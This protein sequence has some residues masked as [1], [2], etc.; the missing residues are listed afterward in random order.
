MKNIHSLLLLERVVGGRCNDSVCC[1]EVYIKSPWTALVIT[2]TLLSE[3][4]PIIE[5][6]TGAMTL[7]L[8]GILNY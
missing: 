8:R 7:Q 4:C 5:D 2:L 6:C 1:T 3:E